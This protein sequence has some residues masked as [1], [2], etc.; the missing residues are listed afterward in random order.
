M[1][2]TVCFGSIRVVVPCG[3][4]DLTV[5]ELQEKACARYRKATA[6]VRYIYAKKQITLW[7]V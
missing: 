1:K 3:S 5:R 4:G 7:P 6:K 2:V